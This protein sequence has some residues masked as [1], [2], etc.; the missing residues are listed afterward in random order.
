MTQECSN[1]EIGLTLRF[2]MA[3]SNLLSG[4]LYGKR[5]WIL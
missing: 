3:R 1:D 5:S 2:F 4:I